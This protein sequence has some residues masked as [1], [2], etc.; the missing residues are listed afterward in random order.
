MSRRKIV[1][2]HKDSQCSSTFVPPVQT[3]DHIH[4][5]SRTLEDHVGDVNCCKFYPSGLVVLSGGS[6]TQ[7]KIWS[8]E[9]GSCART[10]A[11]SHR[12]G[13][14]SVDMVGVGR[15]VVSASRDGTVRLWDCG[16]SKCLVDFTSE[17]ETFH[18]VNCCRVKEC[19]P[20]VNDDDVDKMPEE[21]GTDNKVLAWGDED[22]KLTVVHMATR[23]PVISY[24][25]ENRAACNATMWLDSAHVIGG[26]HDGRIVVLDVVN[27][28]VSSEITSNT[29]AVT[30]ISK[31][32]KKQHFWT[33]FSDGRVAL[34]QHSG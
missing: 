22:G 8:V 32:D 6:D 5:K 14:L 13:V 1:V 10:L 9:D 3:F 21:S 28:K 27:N 7:L 4:L 16:S 12:S 25:H 23:S 15:N 31:S 2:K 33:S 19:D 29:S 20:G 24:H 30:S 17:Q 34:F 11:G 18:Q 26:F